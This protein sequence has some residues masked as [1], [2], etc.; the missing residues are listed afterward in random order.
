[1]GWFKKKTKKLQKITKCPTCGGMLT[2]QTGLEHEF[3]Y[4]NQM[5]HVPDITAMVC[6]DCGEMYFDYTEFERISNYVHEAVDG[7]DETE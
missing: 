4:K 1:M 6:G 3:T 5:V 2:K 7:K